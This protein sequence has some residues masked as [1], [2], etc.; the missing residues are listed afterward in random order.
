MNVAIF[1][2]PRPEFHAEPQPRRQR[3]EIPMLSPSVRLKATREGVSYRT[4]GHAF[5]I[6]RRIDIPIARGAARRTGFAARMPRVPPLWE[7]APNI[8]SRTRSR[9]VVWERHGQWRSSWVW[10]RPV[11][12][13]KNMWSV[14]DFPTLGP[15]NRPT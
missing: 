10:P 3:S 15:A 14:G 2:L 13:A 1:L 11:H 12:P 5:Q 7:A 6:D 9:R 8:M 4:R